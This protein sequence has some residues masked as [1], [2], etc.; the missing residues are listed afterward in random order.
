MGRPKKTKP[1]RPKKGVK[2]YNGELPAIKH[3]EAFKYYYDLGSSRT[4]LKTAKD[5]GVN[6]K[7]LTSWAD[8]EQWLKHIDVLNMEFLRGIRKE[9]ATD[10]LKTSNDL[11]QVTNEAIRLFKNNLNAG[12]I[13]VKSISDLERLV[14]LQYT[15]YGNMLG[16]LESQSGIVKDDSKTINVNVNFLGSEEGDDDVETDES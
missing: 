9:L 4:F 16:E 11:I 10:V 1:G 2:E 6:S 13:N 14:T 5:M 12:N 8:K 15:I 7:T 3:I